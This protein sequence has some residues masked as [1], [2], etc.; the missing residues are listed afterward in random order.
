MNSDR[1]KK[2]RG[3]PLSWITPTQKQSSETVFLFGDGLIK[4]KSGDNSFKSNRELNAAM[5]K[6][7]NRI[8]AAKFVPLPA[9]PSTKLK[10]VE[11]HGSQSS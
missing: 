2:F 4:R 5:G 1:A 3:F 6:Q 8:K 11:L 7:R 9:K 10:L